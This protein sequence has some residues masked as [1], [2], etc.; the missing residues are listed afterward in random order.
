MDGWLEGGREGGRG[1]SVSPPHPQ[2]TWTTDVG[3]HGAGAS[4]WGVPQ[5]R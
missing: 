5:E 4:A 1:A 2:V 3:P